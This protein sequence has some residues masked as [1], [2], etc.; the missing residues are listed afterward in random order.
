[1]KSRKS[2]KTLIVA[3]AVMLSASCA[4]MQSMN[5]ASPSFDPQALSYQISAGQWILSGT[6]GIFSVLHSTGKLSDS[7]FS[8]YQKIS[9][10]AEI[11]LETAQMA[12]KN[13]ESL[14]N[15]ANAQALAVAF[16]DLTRI[17]LELDR[18]YRDPAAIES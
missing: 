3:L 2:L 11:T 15:G 10:T 13:Y 7:A 1:M 17:V 9:G 5:P 8:S 6:D 14:K 12:L 18:L 4:S 16:Q